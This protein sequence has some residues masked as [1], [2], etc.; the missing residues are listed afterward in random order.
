MAKASVRVV[1]H[2]LNFII[3]EKSSDF[4]FIYSLCNFTGKLN[5]SL[6]CNI[7]VI[8]FYTDILTTSKFDLQSSFYLSETREKIL[9]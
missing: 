6:Q 9:T 3:C 4:L 2:E 7:V 1:S 5:A 8:I